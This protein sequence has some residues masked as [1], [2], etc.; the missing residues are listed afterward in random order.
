MLLLPTSALPPPTGKTDQEDDDDDVNFF[1]MLL[2]SKLE[3]QQ[4][5][6]IIIA[7]NPFYT[8]HPLSNSSSCST[9]ELVEQSISPIYYDTQNREK[10]KLLQIA[11]LKPGACH[12][13]FLQD[14]IIP[15]LKNSSRGVR[16]YSQSQ[17]ELSQKLLF[18]SKSKCKHFLSYSNE[19]QMERI[20]LPRSISFPSYSRDC[21]A[22]VGELLGRAKRGRDKNMCFPHT[23]QSFLIGRLCLCLPFVKSNKFIL[24]LPSINPIP[25]GMI[26]RNS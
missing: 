20:I 1:L 17:S 22:A 19:F 6:A 26:R 12:D 15:S 8:M 3:Q 21:T 5:R 11:L 16:P 4:Q 14:D 25:Y 23:P 10:K 9:C 13:I 24:T 18:S 7:P 2:S